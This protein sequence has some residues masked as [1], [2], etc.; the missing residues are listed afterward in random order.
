MSEKYAVSR[1]GGSTRW[2]KV[3]IQVT[4]IGQIMAGL[5]AQRPSAQ[6]DLR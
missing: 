4:R 6:N 2:I 5:T 1:A 3:R